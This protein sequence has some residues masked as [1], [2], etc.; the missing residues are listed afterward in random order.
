[1]SPFHT[2]VHYLSQWLSKWEE[3]HCS[4]P[5]HTSL[6][7]LL[8]AMMT[9]WM[10]VEWFQPVWC[11]LYLGEIETMLQSHNEPRKG[12]S[13]VRENI[14]EEWRAA[15]GAGCHHSRLSLKMIWQMYG[16]WLAY[17]F[18]PTRTR[19]GRYSHKY[20]TSKSSLAI[21]SSGQICGISFPLAMV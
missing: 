9:T 18:L 19:T 20:M 8:V 2:W 14:H 6:S 7:C 17:P 5:K 15:S 21:P 3:G 1:M 11:Q 10:L 4:T 16:R 13:E 12:K